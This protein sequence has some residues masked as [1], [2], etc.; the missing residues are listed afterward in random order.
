MPTFA[1]PEPISATAELVVGDLLIIAG[2]RADTTVEVR[3]SDSASEAD[4]KAV[5]RTRVEYAQGRLLVRTS[6]R[7]TLF[8]KVGSVDVVIELP[9]GSQV[10]C[11]AA[12]GDFRAQ[13]ELGECR[14]RTSMG[15]VHLQD[16]GP[17]HVNTSSG[18]VTVERATG[19]VEITTG[20]GEVRV[21]RVD[22][23]AVIKNSNGDS[24]LGEISGD[25]RMNGA[26]GRL[27]VDRTHAGVV[28]KT[29]NGDVRVGEVVRGAVVMETACGDLELGIR[30]G[31]AARLDI[32][33][34]TGRVYNSLSTAEG[35]APSD[36]IV[37]VRGRTGMGDVVIRRS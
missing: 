12:M 6:K 4:A 34:G 37:E 36:E 14:F 8:G 32:A 30:E 15:H 35:P 26:N 16:T 23:T 11:T 19:H 17:L 18:D 7:N 9:A 25:L 21:R 22:G 33:S 13:G 31:T 10:H 5:N 29:A 2:D 28:A 27:T 20:S 3:P 1:T 24:W